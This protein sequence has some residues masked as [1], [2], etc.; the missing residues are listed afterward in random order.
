MPYEAHVL[1]DNS[2]NF[3][4]NWQHGDTILIAETR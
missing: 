4:W 2:G 3:G 1:G